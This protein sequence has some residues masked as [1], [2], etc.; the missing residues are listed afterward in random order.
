MGRWTSDLQFPCASRSTLVYS[1]DTQSRLLIRFRGS[2]L[3]L[4]FTAAANRCE[5]LVSLDDGDP[6][7][8]NQHSAA[9]KWQSVSAP[10]RAA[11]YREPILQFPFSHN[12]GQRVLARCCLVLGGFIVV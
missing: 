5:G 3:K 2:A 12:R 1:N 10:F 7:P 11:A 8:L 4:I 6:I 9:T